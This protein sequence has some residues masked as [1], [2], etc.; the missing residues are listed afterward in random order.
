MRGPCMSPIE[1]IAH[2]ACGRND[3]RID[4]RRFAQDRQQPIRV[5]F[6][7]ARPGKTSEK[8]AELQWPYSSTTLLAPTL[9]ECASAATPMMV[10]SALP[11]LRSLGRDFGKPRAQDIERA[12]HFERQPAADDHGPGVAGRQ[13]AG[14][15]STESASPQSIRDR[16]S[17]TCVRMPG[18]SSYDVWN[19]AAA[20]R[21]GRDDGGALRLR[22]WRRRVP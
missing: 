18:V 19:R 21:R 7:R 14:P 1:I 15:R 12:V 8:S 11:R 17:A 4:H 16:R 22:D 5:A 3:A 9:I 13:T 10:A 2:R 6:A 20:K